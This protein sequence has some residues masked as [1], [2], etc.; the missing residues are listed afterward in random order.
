VF[1]KHTL[2]SVFLGR[3]DA[4]EPELYV[5]QVH[6]L[7]GHMSLVV[8]GAL[9]VLIVDLI[10]LYLTKD[11]VFGAVAVALVTLTAYRY[12]MLRRY[13]AESRD[14]PED[15]RENLVTMRRWEIEYAVA[16]LLFSA[17][18]GAFTF[19]AMVQSRTD[20][21]VYAAFFTS[22]F[23]G[24]IAI[25]HATHLRIVAVQVVLIMLPFLAGA[26]LDG[27][28]PY[29]F[30]VGLVPL[31]VLSIRSTTGL[32]H[33]MLTKALNSAFVSRVLARQ[34]E[35]AL[36]NMTQGLC[37]VDG[38]G[39]VLVANAQL[40]PVLGIGS[41]NVEVGGALSPSL[42]RSVA[43]LLSTGSAVV[44]T[45]GL[46]G[47]RMVEARIR[48]MAGGGNLLM[49]EDVTE[50]EAAAARI[51]RMAHFDELTG[52][53]NR[54][55]FRD[56]VTRRF[57]TGNDFALLCLDLDQFKEVND[58]LGHPM[59]DRLLVDVAVRLKAMV[60]TTDFVARLG[61]DEFMVVVDVD[62]DEEAIGLLAERLVSRVSQPY[63][64]HEHDIN[65]GLSVGV[66]FSGLHGGAVDALVKNAD[67]ALYRSKREGRGRFCMFHHDM[68]REAQARRQME[69]DMRQA[70]ADEAFTVA[71][72]PIVTSSTGKVSC[73]EALVRWVG[74][75]GRP[76]F[77]D[78]FIPLAEETG[79][80][81][82]IGG[83]VLRKACREAMRWPNETRVAVNL[84]DV[85]FRRGVVVA[86]V[87]EALRLSGLPANRLEVEITESLAM[88][89]KERTVSVLLELRKLGVRIALDDFGTG[90]TSL[91]YLSE[92]PH[93]KVKL[94]RAFVQ[95]LAEDLGKRKTVAF[96]ADLAE[97]NGAD[98]VAEGVEE[99]EQVDLLRS[100]DVHQIQGWYYSKAVPG[101]QVLD[102][103]NS[104]PPGRARLRIVA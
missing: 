92:I 82:E 37:M 97:T 98:V 32:I 3:V 38:E 86:Q 99:A 93:D 80:I 91:Y 55:S 68:D 7:F 69:I 62:G 23:A 90:H 40:G 24:N 61:G 49:V 35:A 77:P 11:W 6:K 20:L 19:E 71:Y 5:E 1:T 79:M 14:F 57:E 74:N 31:Q 66:A 17:L 8:M 16:T 39:K 12:R 70:I 65:V 53:P 83:I 75:D 104:P 56:E 48:P 73:C 96:V 43:G 9:G 22:I 28:E 102:F 30:L 34:L 88:E 54:V 26:T 95:G 76:I 60:R 81:V 101:D 51:S 94:D 100:L 21:H 50:R 45:V 29:L 25:R 103:L 27:N 42:P 47:G 59:G 52:L 67:M 13:E 18:V 36:G 89:D 41:G 10:A 64:I 63:R 78:K 46:E 87:M 44:T 58:T 72:Q 85:Q 15:P 2:E 33:G 4:V 84:S